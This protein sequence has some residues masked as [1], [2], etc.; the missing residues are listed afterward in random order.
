MPPVLTTFYPRVLQFWE[1]SVTSRRK[2]RRKKT[3]AAS[4]APGPSTPVSTTAVLSYTLGFLVKF[5]IKKVTNIIPCNAATNNFLAFGTSLIHFLT[6]HRLN[7]PWPGRASKREARAA[8]P[9]TQVRGSLHLSCCAPG[10]PLSQLLH[11][12]QSNHSRYLRR[13]L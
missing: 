4:T 10:W 1:V 5:H 6:L 12:Q 13:S 11:R 2:V 9:L 7:T 3:R 8:C